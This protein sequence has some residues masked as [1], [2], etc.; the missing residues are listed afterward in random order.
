MQR[1][2]ARRLAAHAAWQTLRRAASYHPPCEPRDRCHRGTRRRG[3]ASAVRA[4]RPTSRHAP[5]PQA[6]AFRPPKPER[7][8]SR[9]GVYFA[10][11][12]GSATGVRAI[13]PRVECRQHRFLPLAGRVGWVCRRKNEL[14]RTVP[15][16]AQHRSARACW[17]NSFFL[18]LARLRE[19]SPCAPT[20][21]R[22]TH[23]MHPRPIRG[24]GKMAPVF[25]LQSA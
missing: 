3:D 20:R 6:T 13:V 22:A 5:A 11:D 12:R 7:A 18:R 24:L 1:P 14:R 25:P 17:Y 9:A 10:G 16:S 19:S 2:S 15:A 23:V 21:S 4:R 8:A